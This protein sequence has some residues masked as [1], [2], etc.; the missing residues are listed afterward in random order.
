MDIVELVLGIFIVLVAAGLVRFF[1]MMAGGMLKVYIKY[2]KSLIPVQPIPPK[3]KLK[4]VRII[5]NDENEV[6]VEQNLFLEELES[7]PDDLKNLEQHL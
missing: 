7:V 3:P 6:R 1:L 5:L 2:R 4:P